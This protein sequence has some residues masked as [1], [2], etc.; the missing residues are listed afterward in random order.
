[1][2]EMM[3]PTERIWSRLLSSKHKDDIYA[4][5]IFKYLLFRQ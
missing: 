2:G 4:R 3:N 5:D 1:M